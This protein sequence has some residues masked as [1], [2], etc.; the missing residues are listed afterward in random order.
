MTSKSESSGLERMMQRQAGPS[1]GDDDRTT[2]RSEL[3]FGEDVTTNRSDL[4]SGKDDDKLSYS[5]NVFVIGDLDSVNGRDNEQ[6]RE[7]W[8]GGNDETASKSEFRRQVGQQ[9]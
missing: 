3:R 7:L 5:R 2:S 6:I 4:R 8:S 9:I 1:C